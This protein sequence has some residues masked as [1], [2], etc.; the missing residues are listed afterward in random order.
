MIDMKKII[1][2]PIMS[3]LILRVLIIINIKKLD[4]STRIEEIASMI[5]GENITE[6]AISQ[7]HE[8]LK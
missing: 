6:S 1:K 5:S 4:K 7:A 3:K 8:L 2:T